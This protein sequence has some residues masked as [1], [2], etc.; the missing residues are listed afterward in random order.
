MTSS[1][2]AFVE[3]SRAH[4]ASRDIDPVYPVLKHLVKDDHPGTAHARVFAYLA[5]YS[6]ASSEQALVQGMD[7]WWLYGTP[8]EVP[9]WAHFPTGVERRSL[10]GGKNM[11]KHLDALTATCEAHGSFEDW[12]DRGVVEGRPT[13]SWERMRLVTSEPWGN[14]RWASYK[15]CEVLW[16]VLD[17]PL[18]AT[19][20]GNEFS[21][22][23]REG[24]ALLGYAFE[25][26]SKGVIAKLDE[27]A[28]DLCDKLT[29]ALGETV[30]IEEFETLLCDWK[31]TVK[32]HYYVGHD[33]DLMLEGA[34]APFVHEEV[35]ARILEARA[36]TLPHEYLGELNGWSGVDKE[37]NAAYRELGAVLTRD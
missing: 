2:P 26:N 5:F 16:K 29:D 21:T 32:G 4:L 14:G 11:M 15:T 35:R 23:P 28:F 25:G 18:E 6:L 10:R 9:P 8:T 36:A 22:G 3:F 7:G 12:L 31:S 17:Y 34:N 30:G 24:L 27:V 13:V 19:D 37:R 20:M 1:W 33:I